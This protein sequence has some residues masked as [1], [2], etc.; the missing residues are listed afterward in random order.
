[1]TTH[2]KLRVLTWDEMPG[3]C[4]AFRNGNL[5]EMDDGHALIVSN[6]SRFAGE[7]PAPLARLLQVFDAHQVDVE[8]TSVNEY[9]IWGGWTQP[10]IGAVSVIGNFVDI[11]HVF[12]IYTDSPSLMTSLSAAIT[13]A[14]ER[15]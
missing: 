15:L 3:A 12:Q 14:S 2:S 9:P 6:G 11:S 13:K 7:P 10:P 4:D 8:H 1:M 5:I